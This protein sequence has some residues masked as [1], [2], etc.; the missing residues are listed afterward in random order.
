MP[1]RSYVF[2]ISS[3]GKEHKRSSCEGEHGKPH[4]GDSKVEQAFYDVQVPEDTSL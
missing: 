4:D 1:R 2:G 3:A